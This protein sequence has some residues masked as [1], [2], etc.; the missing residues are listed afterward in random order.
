M[1]LII[2]F[3][4]PLRGGVC[5]ESQWKC[6]KPLALFGIWSLLSQE[7]YHHNVPACSWN[8]QQVIQGVCLSCGLIP[9]GWEK[10]L[11]SVSHCRAWR[12]KSF[13]SGFQQDRV[14]VSL[15]TSCSHL[16]QFYNYIQN[17]EILKATKDNQVPCLRCLF[18]CPH[19]PVPL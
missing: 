7:T 13:P 15:G 4:R 5:F 18:S 3:P 2:T 9:Q 14:P 12:K 19:W 6:H 17:F 16:L 8:G 1:A 10:P 11:W